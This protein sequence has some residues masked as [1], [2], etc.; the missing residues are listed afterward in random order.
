MNQRTID[1]IR[2]GAIA[3]EQR[4]LLASYE[5][6]QICRAHRP[7]GHLINQTL[8]DYS[9][10]LGLPAAEPQPQQPPAL[11]RS[12]IEL[13]QVQAE[14]LE[15]TDILTA[16]Q[17]IRIAHTSDPSQAAIA[18]Q[19]RAYAARERALRD[20]L[21]Q[22]VADQQIAIIPAGFRCYTKQRI[23]SL[24]GL[25]QASFPFDS[26]FFP[27]NA[28]ASMIREPEI[29][30]NAE[31]PGSYALCIKDDPVRAENGAKG[32]H[33]T[34]TTQHELDQQVQACS[35]QKTALNRYLDSTMGYYT[36]DERHQ[37]ILAHYNWHALSGRPSDLNENLQA[38]NQILNRRLNRL[39]RT[40]EQCQS[41]LFVVDHSGYQ[42]LTVDQT[43]YSIT[44]TADLTCALSQRFPEAR[45]SLI[46]ANTLTLETAT[47]LLLQP[48]AG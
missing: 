22:A 6:L 25:S 15:T 17:L 48:G 28:I 34:R 7:N 12:A 36:L 2:D 39:F 9:A 11:S 37:H 1:S 21:L 43:H 30:L 16:L 27:P 24:L 26:G 46:Q 4:D 33:F 41:A 23:R 29:A 47:H 20:A 5:L 35:H 32:I 45:I 42:V 38:I 3:L 8:R 31:I 18:E 13:L 10:R 19:A 14:A 40:L 44:D